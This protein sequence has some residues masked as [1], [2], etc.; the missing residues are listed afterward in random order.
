MYEACPV[1]WHL[2]PV[3][4]PAAWKKW[5]A[6]LCRERKLKERTMKLCN[7]TF[8]QALAGLHRG[9][10]WAKRDWF[11]GTYLE[12]RGS[13]IFICGNGRN[14]NIRWQSYSEAVEA[15]D[16]YCVR[17][18]EVTERDGVEAIIRHQ[19]ETITKLTDERDEQRTRADGLRAQLDKLQGLT[20][21][22]PVLC[23]VDYSADYINDRISE[24]TAALSN[25]LGAAEV[26]VEFWRSKCNRLTGEG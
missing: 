10:H 3:F 1:T 8:D 18:A 12:Y 24:E 19:S 2:G 4:G 6:E 7:K 11:S 15:S 22:L 17:G 5:H 23:R 21:Y 16:W 20:A 25:M 14:G 9:E 13:A 26:Q